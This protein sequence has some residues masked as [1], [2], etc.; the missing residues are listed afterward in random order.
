MRHVLIIH[1]NLG[2]NVISVIEDNT[3]N[4]L[5]SLR[6]IWVSFS[7]I[8]RKLC[9]LY[10]NSSW[11]WGSY[12]SIWTG[13]SPNK[14]YMTYASEVHILLLW[15]R[16]GHILPY[17]PKWHE[18]FAILY[19]LSKIMQVP[20]GPYTTGPYSKIVTGCANKDK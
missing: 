10:R 20:S 19:F 18:L 8:Y 17:D 5:P 11:H 15:W 12:G 4:N 14:Y 6:F 3:F 13:P 16:T 1:G 9:S 7:I 2:H